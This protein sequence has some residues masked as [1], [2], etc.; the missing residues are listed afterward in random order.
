MLG[1][2]ITTYLITNL[3]YRLQPHHTRNQYLK[4][5]LDTYV[6]VNIMPTSRYNLFKD[7]ELKKLDPSNMEIGT[8]T[9]DKVKILGSCKFYLVH[10]DTKMLL[11]VTFFVVK[12]DGSVLL[13]CTITLVLGL[14]QPR[15]R[16]DYL[17]PRAS[18][19][20]S[21]EDHHKKQDTKQLQLNYR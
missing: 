17:P 3:P 6:D 1:D 7:P 10:P 13:S 20:T 9:T 16:L 2:G 4:G 15:T 5:R 19:I 12:N 11:K 8:Y 18:L 21:S 14:K